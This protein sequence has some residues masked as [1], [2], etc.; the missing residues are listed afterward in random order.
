MRARTRLRIAWLSS[1]ARKKISCASFDA[2][3]ASYYCALFFAL[4]TIADV[5]QTLHNEDAVDIA[6]RKRADVAILPLE[7]TMADSP[8]LVACLNMIGAAGRDAPVAILLNKMFKSAVAKLEVIRNYSHQRDIIASFSVLPPAHEPL[9][10]R[11]SSVPSFSLPF[12]AHSD[13]GL[14]APALNAD[15]SS[16]HYSHDL[17][18]TGGPQRMDEARY[19]LRRA[20]MGNASMRARLEAARVRIFLSP[21]GR[22]L[23]MGQYVS[24][25]AHTK[26]WFSTT[27]HS[28]YNGPHPDGDAVTP[29]FFE[30]LMS[31]RSLLLCNRSPK[32]YLPLGIVEGV[33]VAMFNSSEEFYWKVIYYTRS[34]AGST[35]RLAMVAAA[36]SLAL[37][38]HT[39]AVRAR[40]LEE[41]LQWALMRRKR[42]VRAM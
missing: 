25:M 6:F 41:R 38:R 13:F 8:G 31:G 28:A 7:C 26:V 2:S 29:R 42:P 15:Q 32:S 22:M 35:E 14:L 19:M 3:N 36:R 20:T 1:H 18:F 9:Y 16:A 12:A 33:H 34:K 21:P 11:L 24:Q 40:E 4:R 10:T 23:P 17:G 30:V 39:W 37:A 27:E 5:R